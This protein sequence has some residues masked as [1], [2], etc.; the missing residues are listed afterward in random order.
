[1]IAA[2]DFVSAGS[3]D[4]FSPL[5]AELVRKGRAPE[6]V[7]RLFSSVRR[8]LYKNVALYMRI[9]ESRLNYERF[10][11]PENVKRARDFA[12]VHGDSLRK[13]GRR[14][15]VDPRVIVAILL[16]ETQLGRRTGNHPVVPTLATFAIMKD[17]AHRE[18]IWNL[19]SPQDRKRWSRGTFDEK[20]LRRAR[21]AFDELNALASLVERGEWNAPFWR[22]SFMGAVGWAQF[23]PSS[24]LRYGVDGNGDGAVDLFHPDDAFMS[25]AHYLHAHG[26]KNGASWKERIRII[27]TYNNSTP[28][29]RT[30]L[31]VAARLPAF[32]E[33][34]ATKPS[35]TLR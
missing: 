16:V 29:A 35:I 8:P 13:A 19:L 30:V 11:K 23:L 26:W 17:K 10:L 34:T 24:L 21:W 31:Q 2:A 32:S 28:Y 25:I 22:G 15:G 6:A 3:S 5:K 1:M 20:L 18:R 33:K 9:R 14:F 7:A 4:P 12:R 27:R